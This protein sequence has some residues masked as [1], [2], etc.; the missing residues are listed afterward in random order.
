M[1]EGLFCALQY[2]NEVQHMFL[3]STSENTLKQARNQGGAFRGIFPPLNFKTLHSN[4]DILSWN[5]PTDRKFRKWLVFNNNQQAKISLITLK[6][7][8]QFARFNSTLML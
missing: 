1:T 7:Y 3:Q 5:G 2:I 8:Q 6:S 4:F